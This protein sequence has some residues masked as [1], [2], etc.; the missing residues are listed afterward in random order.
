MTCVSSGM[1]SFEGETRV[2]KPK[3]IPSLRTIQRKKRFRRLH[4]LP[5]EGL[6]KK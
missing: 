6:G 4:A 5:L 2:H 3:S 1:I